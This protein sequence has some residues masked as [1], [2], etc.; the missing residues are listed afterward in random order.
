M[1]RLIPVFVLLIATAGAAGAANTHHHAA[2]KISLAAARA[3][4]LAKVP[5]GKVQSGELEREHGRLIY[6]FDIAVAGKPGIEEIQVSAITGKVVSKTHETP[7]GEAREKVLEKAE[8][9]TG[10]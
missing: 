3:A 6:S 4:A 2:A 10:H 5:G 9:K 1:K 7:K 8:P